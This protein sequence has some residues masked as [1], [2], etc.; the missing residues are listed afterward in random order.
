MKK[1]FLLIVFS[2]LFL[3]ANAQQ[4]YFGV[5][6]SYVNEME[7]CGEIFTENNIQK[8][9]YEMFADHNC[10]LVRLRLWHT[11]SWYDNLNSGNRYSDYTDV[12]KSMQRAQA[13]GMDV[14]LDF[15]LSDIWA[16]PSNQVVPAAWSGVVNNLN[17]LK[18]SLY[19]Y[20][21]KTLTDLNAA[22]LLPAMVQIGNETNKGILLSQAVN[23]AGWSLDWSRNTTLFN[24]AIQAVRDVEQSANASIKIVLHIADPRHGDWYTENFI[25]NGVTDFD[26][27]GLSYYHEWHGE[28][29]ISQVGNII[30]NLIQDHGKEVMIVEAGYPWTSSFDDN[31]NNILGMAAPGYGPLSPSQQEKWLTDLSAAV[32]NN[33]GSGVIYW[34]PA[35]VSSSCSTQWAQGSHY[36]NATFFDFQNNLLED[37]G[38]KWLDKATTAID[39]E[40][41]KR[42]FAIS[43]DRSGNLTISR[44]T[45]S[46]QEK[47]TF[48]VYTI[49]GEIVQK[50]ELL[51]GEIK[52]VWQI[53]PG[54]DGIY[55]ILV[56]QG[57][58]QVESLK[59]LFLK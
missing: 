44:S 20:V 33:G 9:V 6:L 13:E 34:E 5:D 17:V 46:Q 10:N 35:W 49:N 43:W 24:S 41:E 51:P 11:P 39:F 8:D 52:R 1:I 7:D 28:N 36:E 14:L 45:N 50:G 48:Q 32:I 55:G 53:S 38:I 12:K 21:H 54:A 37:G 27:V 56:K 42:S 19:N 4:A 23:D 57:E 25:S 40:D 16:D 22:G 3:G 31:A 26:I 47:I 58:K 29:S 18:D 59:M 2:L 30:K 15:H